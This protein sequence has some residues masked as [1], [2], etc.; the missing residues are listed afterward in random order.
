MD[1]CKYVSASGSK[2]HYL[3]IEGVL[4][5]DVL[6][7]VGVSPSRHAQRMT[8]D[9]VIAIAAEEGLELEERPCG[10]VWVW[11]WAR[12]DDTRWPCY[13]EQRQALNWMRDRLKTRRVSRNRSRAGI[14]R[15]RSGTT[16]PRARHGESCNRPPAFS[17]RS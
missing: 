15:A 13:L 9:E 11:G 1:T 14:M 16:S 5:P 2:H 8:D 17:A 12:D 4:V 7:D 10:D 6:A 3:L